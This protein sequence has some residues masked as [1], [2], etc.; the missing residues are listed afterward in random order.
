MRHRP[1]DRLRAH[2]AELGDELVVR[3]VLALA[4]LQLVHAVDPVVR[5]DLLVERHA[6]PELVHELPDRR[7]SIARAE[8]VQHHLADVPAGAIGGRRPLLG[9]SDATRSAKRANSSSASTRASG[10]VIRFGII[11]CLLLSMVSST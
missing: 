4:D 7:L 11:S 8:D 9:V 5:F 1:F 2:G 6:P 10:R 3:Q